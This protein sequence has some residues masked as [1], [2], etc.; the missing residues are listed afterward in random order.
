MEIWKF[1]IEFPDFGIGIAPN[2]KCDPR[3]MRGRV[4]TGARGCDRPSSASCGSSR[5]CG[6]LPRFLAW[7][8]SSAISNGMAVLTTEIRGM[9]QTS[10]GSFSTVSKRNFASKYAFESSQRDLH[11]ALLCTVL[12]SHSSTKKMLDFSLKNCDVFQNV[13]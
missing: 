3:Y 6:P 2:L 13:C 9:R 12:K 11:N 7:E 4:I 8:P 5:S 10:Q 1:E